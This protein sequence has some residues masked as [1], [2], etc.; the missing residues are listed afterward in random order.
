MGILKPKRINSDREHRVH[1]I[2]LL[3]GHGQHRRRAGLVWPEFALGEDVRGGIFLCV[4]DAINF[5]TPM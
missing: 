1:Y 2:H 5:D 3:P 4:I